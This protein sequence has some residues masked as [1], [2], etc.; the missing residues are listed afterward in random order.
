MVF[1]YDSVINDAYSKELLRIISNEGLV[2]IVGGPDDLVMLTR[3]RCELMR[4]MVD[5]SEIALVKEGLRDIENG[6][7]IPAEHVMADLKK[8]FN[9]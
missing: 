7:M 2:Q 5:S 6:D 4:S 1:L 9:L 8:E 3:E